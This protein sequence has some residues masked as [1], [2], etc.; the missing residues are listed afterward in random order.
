MQMIFPDGDTESAELLG[1]KR[2]ATLLE[3]LRKITTTLLLILRRLD[4]LL[5]PLSFARQ[6]DGVTIV[7]AAGSISYKFV[8]GVKAQLEKSDCRIL[9]VIL[10][11]VDMER[12]ATTAVITESIM[13]GIME[14]IMAAAVKVIRETIGEI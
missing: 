1:G 3:A 5:T 14:S 10:N 4:P 11:K 6:C 2:F 9:G 12:Q 13:A 7:I 8:Q